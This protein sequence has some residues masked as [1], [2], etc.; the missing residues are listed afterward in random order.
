MLSGFLI[1]TI[2]PNTNIKLQPNIHK[3]SSLGG[4]KAFQTKRWLIERYNLKSRVYTQILRKQIHECKKVCSGQCE[5]GLRPEETSS[6]LTVLTTLPVYGLQRGLLCCQ[7][8]LA[9]VVLKM[10]WIVVE[11]NPSQGRLEA[12]TFHI[13]QIKSTYGQI[14]WTIWV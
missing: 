5:S 13:L 10:A 6:W 8:M 14:I 7:E 9:E 12:N 2:T 1:R 4:S 3:G 11:Y